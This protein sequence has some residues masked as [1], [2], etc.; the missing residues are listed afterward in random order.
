MNR[1]KSLL[2]AAL[3]LTAAPVLG[4]AETP[5]DPL[6][7]MMTYIPDTF[8][9]RRHVQFGDLSAWAESWDAVPP[10]SDSTIAS[11]VESGDP[12]ERRTAKLWWNVMALQTFP[13]SAL[14]G[15]VQMRASFGYDTLMT[16][17]SLEAGVVPDQLSVLTLTSDREAMTAALTTLG[18]TAEP[19][20]GGTLYSLRGDDE[21]DLRADLPVIAKMATVNRIAVLDNGTVLIAQNTP[22]IERAL[23]AR[24]RQRSLAGNEAVQSLVQALR[25]EQMSAYGSLTGFLMMDYLVVMNTASDPLNMMLT[26]DIEEMQATLNSPTPE[27]PVEALPAYRLAGLSVSRGDGVT[28]YAVSLVLLPGRD[29]QQAADILGRRFTNYIS[30]G[31]GESMIDFMAPRGITFENAFGVQTQQFPVAVI[32]LAQP[33]PVMTFE[34]DYSTISA[35][36]MS[37]MGAYAA[38]DLGFLA[39]E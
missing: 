23:A 35:M 28:Y 24:A 7:E 29:A 10:S 20:E 34:E 9:Y 6:L 14:S 33:D 15:D 22:S 8:A 26:M 5:A 2:C 21:M 37:W 32:V 17:Q 27:T 25:G 13:S 3:L 36:F 39:L 31:N 30:T 38:R 11:M 18:Y 4:Q 16:Q 19:I 1:V 12:I